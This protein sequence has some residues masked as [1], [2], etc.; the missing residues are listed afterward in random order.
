MRAVGG[1]QLSPGLA[2]AGGQGG[3]AGEEEEEE[4]GGDEAVE[5]M[6]R[7]AILEA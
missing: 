4:E 3:A 5:I 2:V 6:L 7:S 1:C